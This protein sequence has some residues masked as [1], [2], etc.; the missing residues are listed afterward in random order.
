MKVIC[1]ENLINLE[2][3]NK[4]TLKKNGICFESS[5]KRIYLNNKTKNQNVYHHDFIINFLLRTQEENP[6][7]NS[8]MQCCA[9]RCNAVLCILEIPG[10]QS[11]AGQ[12]VTFTFDYRLLKQL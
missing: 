10:I 3:N 6:E 12:G 9:V 2:T 7:K 5:I 1:R 8:A 11:T 4:H